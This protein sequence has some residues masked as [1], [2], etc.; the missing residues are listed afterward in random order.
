MKAWE[1]EGTWVLSLPP[2]CLNYRY[3]PVMRSDLAFSPQVMQPK[4]SLQ[5]QCEWSGKPECL[6]LY[7]DISLT[8]G[9]PYTDS[10]SFPQHTAQGK[11]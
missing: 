1:G 11:A 10:L 8:P 2:N 3:P 7:K 5:Q 6:A 9:L 4:C